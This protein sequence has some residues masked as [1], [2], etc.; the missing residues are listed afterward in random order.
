MANMTI[1]FLKEEVKRQIVFIS[2]RENH[3]NNLPGYDGVTSEK[4][5]FNESPTTGV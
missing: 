5:I 4:S 3:E 1:N 2:S